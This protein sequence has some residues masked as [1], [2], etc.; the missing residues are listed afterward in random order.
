MRRGR[1]FPGMATAR[2]CLIVALMSVGDA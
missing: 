1:G 2:V